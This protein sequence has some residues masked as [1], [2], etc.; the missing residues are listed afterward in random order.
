MVPVVIKRGN[1]NSYYIKGAQAEPLMKYAGKVVTLQGTV[2]R[3]RNSPYE[4]DLTVIKI[5]KVFQ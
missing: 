5:V 3:E 1:K 4:W 2:S